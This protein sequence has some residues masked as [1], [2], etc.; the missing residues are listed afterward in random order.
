LCFNEEKHD[1]EASKN[2]WKSLNDRF[3]ATE[4][5][6]KYITEA[7]YKVE[8]MWECSWRDLK[9]TA[10]FRNKYLYPGEDK[11]YMRESEILKMIQDD[12]LFGA[13][14]VDITVPDDLREYFSEMTP[15]FKNTTINRADIGDYM[16]NYL[17]TSKQKFSERRS[18]IGSMFAEKIL[19]ITPLLKWYMEHGLIVTCVHQ[20]I[21]FDPKDCFRDFGEQVSNDRRAGEF[22]WSDVSANRKNY[23]C[24]RLHLHFFFLMLF[25]N[26]FTM[27]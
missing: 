18:L 2:G 7:G 1:R 15:I 3:Q 11:V 4:E 20:V 24:V 17:E 14:E 25:F 21:Q 26:E 8:E 6:T 13:I 23:F 22:L 12:S 9:K 16:S 10:E 27:G 5:T 19:L